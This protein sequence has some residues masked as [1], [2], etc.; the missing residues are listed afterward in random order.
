[1]DLVS[2]RL[3][4]DRVLIEQDLAPE[5]SEGGIMLVDGK[6]RPSSG[7]VVAVGPG[8]MTKKGRLIP[9]ATRID[10]RV[11]FKKYTQYTEINLNGGTYL[12][13]RDSDVMAEEIEDEE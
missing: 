13:M 7:K 8:R 3:L 10:K 4:D 9:M 5:E 2:I 6:N 1:M 12:I 11:L